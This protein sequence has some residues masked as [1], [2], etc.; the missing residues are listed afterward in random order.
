MKDPIRFISRLIQG[1]GIYPPDAIKRVSMDGGDNS[2]KVILNIFNKH[3]TEDLSIAKKNKWGSKEGAMR[4]GGGE[5][6]ERMGERTEHAGGGGR[7]NEWGSCQTDGAG[8]DGGGGERVRMG[9]RTGITMDE[10]GNMCSGVNRSIV[11]AYCEDLEENYDNIRTILELLRFD[12]MNSVVAADY[13]L[14]DVLLGLSGHGGK[15]ACIY[16]EASKGLEVGK[17]KLSK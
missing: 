16:C 17:Y 11:L 14:L 9:E 8:G 4:D 7:G 6:R 5:E 2:M 13:K 12:E 10:K 3:Q 15:F 1:R